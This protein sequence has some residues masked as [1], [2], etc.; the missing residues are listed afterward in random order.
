[1]ELRSLTKV[2]QWCTPAKS[3]TPSEGISEDEILAD[4]KG[5]R[6]GKQQ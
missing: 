2:S 5:W 4:F 3:R 6:A 1:L